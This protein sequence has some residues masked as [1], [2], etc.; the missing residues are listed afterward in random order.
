MHHKFD[1]PSKPSKGCEARCHLVVYIKLSPWCLSQRGCSLL[2]SQGGN[3]WSSSSR[4]SSSSANVTTPVGRFSSWVHFICYKMSIVLSCQMQTTYL[5]QSLHLFVPSF[6]SS[7]SS[8]SPSHT[9]VR[10]A[11]EK[12][13]FCSSPQ[14]R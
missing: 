6:S 9:Q 4:S 10:N 13:S 11:F 12:Q 5:L 3:N 7:N 14:A 1:R 2:S 8:S